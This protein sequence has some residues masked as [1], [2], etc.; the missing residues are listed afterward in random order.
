[1]INYPK[2]KD[3]IMKQIIRNILFLALILLSSCELSMLEYELPEDQRGKGEPY[4][5]VNEYGEFT[6]EYN[7][8]V[9]PLNGDP[10]NYIATMNDSVL[11]FMDNMPDK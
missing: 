9:T 7:K 8:N 3:S 11:W 5:E 6:Y 10:Q 2:V 1:M 4:T